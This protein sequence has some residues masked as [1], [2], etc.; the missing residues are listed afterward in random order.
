MPQNSVQWRNMP[1]GTGI[2]F[3]RLVIRLTQTDAEAQDEHSRHGRP[4]LD[5][6]D[7]LL[8]SG[9]RGA[10]SRSQSVMSLEIVLH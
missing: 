8:H 9:F 4:D 10:L 3:S 2:A 5:F 7:A 6:H 1:C